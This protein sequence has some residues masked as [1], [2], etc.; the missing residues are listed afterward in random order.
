MRGALVACLLVGACHWTRYDAKPTT[1]TQMCHACCQQAQDAC[2]LD[3]DRPGYYCPRDYQECVTACDAADE[4]QICVIQTRPKVAATATPARASTAHPAAAV[5]KIAQTAR[6][7]CDNKGTWELVISE[8]KGRGANCTALDQ[9]PRQVTFRIERH[10]DLFALDD[11]APAAGWNDG[12]SV[13]NKHDQCGVTL[14]RDN[15][16]DSDRPRRMTVMMTEK[17]GEVM[18]TFHYREELP[19]PAACELDAT[20]T[21][22]LIAPAPAAPPPQ[23]LPP[24]PR[25]Q[26][27]EEPARSG[28]G[29]P[30]PKEPR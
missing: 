21:G 24:P 7:E 6:G 14:T 4:N 18:G 30:G 11:L 25:P 22:M 19:M 3:T 15:H 16:V 13:D 2:K 8:A 10:Q 1:P 5:T 23:Q 26:R 20:V 17:N 28:V 27:T 29:V 12:F 9:I